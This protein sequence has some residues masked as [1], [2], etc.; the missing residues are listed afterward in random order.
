[1]AGK[2]SL[3][4]QRIT[5]RRREFITADIVNSEFRQA[6]SILREENLADHYLNGLSQVELDV[7]SGMSSFDVARLG[8]SSN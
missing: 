1:M 8:K 5:P 2:D 7:Q 3:L 6:F 4:A